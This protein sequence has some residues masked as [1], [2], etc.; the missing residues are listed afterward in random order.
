MTVAVRACCDLMASQLASYRLSGV[1][2]WI[3]STGAYHRSPLLHLR[4]RQLQVVAR[5][6][7]CERDC[8]LPAIATRIEQ[9]TAW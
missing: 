9:G 8:L 5:C 4:S 1:V 2:F 3:F 6:R 7:D